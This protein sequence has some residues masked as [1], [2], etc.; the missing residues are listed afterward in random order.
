MGRQDIRVSA[1]G[2]TAVASRVPYSV[3]MS[4]YVKERPEW[5]SQSLDSMLGQTVSPS[6]I[7]I[8]EDGPITPELSDV[9][10]RYNATYPKLFNFVV[11]DENH[12]LGY[13]LN[14]GVLACSNEI[15]ARMD[16]DDIARADRMEKQ[17]SAIAEG[18]DMVGSD[19]VEFEESP[20]EPVAS[21]A[22]PKGM[23]NI[24][25]YSKRRN[26]FR[27]PSMT[28]KK[29]K[30]LEAGNYSS[31]YLFF[32]DWDLFN[33]MLSCGCRAENIAEPLVAMRVSGDF[34]AR[35]GGAKYLGYAYDFK[36][37]QVS[38]GYFTKAD[39][40]ASFVPHAIVCLMPN[41]V[42]S[43]VYTK[44]LRRKSSSSH[45]SGGGD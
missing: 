2:N 17:L 14:K 10:E 5:L 42:R 34:Y 15:I 1:E 38:R 18:L 44:M 7:V 45:E 32:E 11:L 27:H 25:A 39:F 40:F 23:D 6:E 9:L 3:L 16:T 37:A 8:V 43:F 22:L 30:V 31:E 26:P 41:S 21:T 28:F 36:K 35:R 13:A 4:L 24:L 20:D 29:T 12:G 19:V 33:R